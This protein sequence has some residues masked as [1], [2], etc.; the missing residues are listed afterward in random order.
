MERARKRHW[1]VNCVLWTR[2]PQPLGHRT[3]P[4]SGLLRTQPHSRRWAACLRAKLHLF[5]AA[6]SRK[7]QHL[8]CTSDHQVL[9]FP[10]E[11][12]SLV[13]ETL[14]TAAVDG[15]F[16]TALH[17][18][19]S[20]FPRAHRHSSMCEVGKM[21]WARFSYQSSVT[22]TLFSIKAGSLQIISLILKRPKA[23]SL[24]I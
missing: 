20:L 12:W 6:P 8:S 17:Y 3:K 16:M 15:Q 2:G 23:A 9:R 13:P 18:I 24:P 5:A 10:Q 1:W 21:N 19:Q 14:G 4:V 22:S 11:H 7:H